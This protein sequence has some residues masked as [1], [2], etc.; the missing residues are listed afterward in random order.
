MKTQFL[1]CYEDVI[2]N[3]EVS[4]MNMKC[5]LTESKKKCFISFL[6]IISLYWW[7]RLNKKVQPR[8]L[9]C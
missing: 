9:K 5:N 7:K 8:Q 3:E 2:R 6:N 1:S 4:K